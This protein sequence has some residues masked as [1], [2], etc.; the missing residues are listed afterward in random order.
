MSPLQ[1]FSV[2]SKRKA[3]SDEFVIMDID[4]DTW[5]EEFVDTITQLRK[6]TFQSELG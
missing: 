2:L 5:G 6:G 1:S 3:I 4:R